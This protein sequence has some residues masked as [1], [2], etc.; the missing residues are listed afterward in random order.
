M[1]ELIV[2]LENVGRN[3]LINGE[4]ISV[5]MDI[6][7]EVKLGE[8]IAVTGPSGSGKSTLMNII[9]GL[10][11]PSVGKVTWPSF[12]ARLNLRPRSV[13]VAFQDASLIPSLSVVENIELPLLLSGQTQNVRNMATE[14]LELFGLPEL[15]DRLPEELSGGQMQR[16]AICRAVI[17]KP[18]L[19]LADEPTGQLDQMNAQKL[20]STLLAYVQEIGSTL[21]LATHDKSVA[22]KM[23]VVWHLDHGKMQN[24]V[25]ES[26]IS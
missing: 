4:L 25:R 6:S 5:L 17:C 22:D 16:V 26:Q 2:V 13:G 8:A 18:K 7:C 12:D 24:I 15:A 10:D 23:S 20:V 14:C 21:M 9:A 3:Y 19:I 11:K 1:T